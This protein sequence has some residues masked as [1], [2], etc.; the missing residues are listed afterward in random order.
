[1]AKGRSSSYL[2]SSSSIVGS[3]S[4]TNIRETTTVKKLEMSASATFTDFKDGAPGGS[5][6]SREHDMWKTGK[7]EASGFGRT[8]SSGGNSSSSGSSFNWDKAVNDAFKN[9]QSKK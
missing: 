5:L 6:W 3:Y 7:T 9:N 1:M 2:N 8:M 4:V